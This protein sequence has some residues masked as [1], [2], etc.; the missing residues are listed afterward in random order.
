MTPRQTMDG[1]NIRSPIIPK[2]IDLAGKTSQLIMKGG[3]S[4]E[5]QNYCISISNQNYNSDT[6]LGYYNVYTQKHTLSVPTF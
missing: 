1:E 3:D 2:W 5:F 4:N 6:S